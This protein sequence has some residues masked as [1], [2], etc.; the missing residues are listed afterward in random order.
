L[1]TVLADTD[2]PTTQVKSDH[3]DHRIDHRSVL[4]MIEDFYGLPNVGT[5][6]GAA[7][8]VEAVPE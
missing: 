4:R 5:S 1:R 3:Y 2:P 6:A 7:P 8:I